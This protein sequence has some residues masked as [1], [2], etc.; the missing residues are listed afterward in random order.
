MSAAVDAD[1]LRAVEQFIFREA[2]LQ[3]EHAYEE[4]EALWTD[5]G[6]YWV[7]YGGDD[8]PSGREAR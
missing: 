8:L 4:W 6:V 1:L 2:R 7:P 5:D 3:D